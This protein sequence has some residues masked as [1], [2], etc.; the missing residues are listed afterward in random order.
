MKN[1]K[2]EAKGARKYGLEP[3]IGP[4]KVLRNNNNGT[5]RLQMGAVS[6]NIN[7]RKL[8]PYRR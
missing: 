7:I 5:L 3:W 8:K 2:A 4:Y 6:D 1:P